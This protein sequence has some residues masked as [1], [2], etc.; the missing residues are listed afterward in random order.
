M[1]VTTIGS[2]RI[3]KA[4]LLAAEYRNAAQEGRIRE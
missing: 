4:M 3:A 1:I 2:L